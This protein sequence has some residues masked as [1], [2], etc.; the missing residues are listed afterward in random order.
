MAITELL[1][2]VYL[3]LLFRFR[4]T[5]GN[6]LYTSVNIEYVCRNKMSRVSV[7]CQFNS[8]DMFTLS[9]EC[10]SIILLLELH[11]EQLVVILS[12]R[13]PCCL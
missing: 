7:C 2:P 9:R 10:S 1:P 13:C 11:Y 5:N 6:L 12:L 4:L 8:I 3:L